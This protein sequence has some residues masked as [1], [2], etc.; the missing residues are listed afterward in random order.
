MQ[1]EWRPIIEFGYYEETGIATFEISN[2]GQVRKA[3]YY[4]SAMNYHEPVL[5]T[6]TRSPESG[7]LRVLLTHDGMH[8]SIQI[9]RYVAQYFVPNPQNLKF[10]KWRDGNKE[11]CC[12]DNLYWTSKMEE[13]YNKARSSGRA[14]RCYA[15]DHELLG[16]FDKITHAER[17]MGI[18]GI[19]CRC[20]SRKVPAYLGLIWR[21]VE[22]DEFYKPG[23]VPNTE[24]FFEAIKTDASGRPRCNIRQYSFDGVLV[25][26]YET[27]EAICKTYKV[28]P[29]EVRKNCKRLYTQAG[30]F[31][32]R[33]VTDDELFEMSEEGRMK[34]IM[35]LRAE[36]KNHGVIRQYTK[37]GI[38]VAEFASS[39]EAA[40]VVETADPSSILKCCKR[41]KHYKSVRG[42]L[43]RFSNDDEIAIE[44]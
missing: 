36:S 19:I 34:R 39:Y 13:S 6:R 12:A 15:P 32:W 7:I 25:G 40:Q 1:E 27:S 9:H 26:E 35:Q 2:L 28:Q 21:Y 31:V 10:V 18:K 38:L 20:C 3:G 11:N 42:F 4:D 43:W 17:A 41:V 16:E 30:G 29:G 8:K 24:R 5:Y 37:D 14:V 22:D 23:A 44:G 33:Y